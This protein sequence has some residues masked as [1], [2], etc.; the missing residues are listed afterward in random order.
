MG[1]THLRK[2]GGQASGVIGFGSAPPACVPPPH[3][4]GGHTSVNGRTGQRRNR[5]RFSPSGAARHL[6]INV[7]DIPLNGEDYK[8]SLSLRVCSQGE[9]PKGCRPRWEAL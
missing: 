5:V 4:W 8:K 7:E 2:W 6:P 3:E 1:R 9:V